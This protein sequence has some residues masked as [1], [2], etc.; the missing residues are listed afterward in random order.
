MFAEHTPTSTLQMAE[1]APDKAAC[2]IFSQKNGAGE[3]TGESL[4]QQD[5]TS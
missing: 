5:Q 3:D 2:F 4:G 1:T